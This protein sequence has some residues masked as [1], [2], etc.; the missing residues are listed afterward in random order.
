MA[1]VFCANGMLTV[2]VTGLDRLWALKS[3]LEF[4][5]E[6]VERIEHDPTAQ[7]PSL[8]H[9]KWPGTYIPGVI[10][11]GTFYMGRSRTFFVVRNPERAVVIWLRN[12]P[13]EKL[14]IEADD[15][16]EMVRRL[17]KALATHQTAVEGPPPP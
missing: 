16:D 14:V 13:Y 8:L 4:P 1:N 3:H 5:L 17:R 15:P 6:H 10:A 11:A 7:L 9:A 2:D 12:E